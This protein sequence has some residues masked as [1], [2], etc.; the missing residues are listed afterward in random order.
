MGTHYQIY[1]EEAHDGEIK[2]VGHTDGDGHY[3]S[4]E[5]NGLFTEDNPFLPLAEWDERE[6]DSPW[7]MNEIDAIMVEF[8]DNSDWAD[9]LIELLLT[10]KW[11]E[12]AEYVKC[13]ANFRRVVG[14][15]RKTAA[16]DTARAT[17]C[18]HCNHPLH[19]IVK[20]L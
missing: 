5:D 12:V 6:E 16:E 14:V 17:H 18:P 15:V 8:K 11:S 3:W 2:I 19:I 7:Q 13:S 10:C 9:D 20:R 4:A 1:Y